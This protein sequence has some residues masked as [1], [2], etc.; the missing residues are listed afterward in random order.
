MALLKECESGTTVLGIL[1]PWYV[2]IDGGSLKRRCLCV[3]LIGLVMFQIPAER[4]WLDLWL[5]DCAANF[6]LIYPN[7][8]D[9]G[10]G[11]PKEAG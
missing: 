7:G 3:I 1:V 5:I 11:C 6:R 9:H 10:F 8:V 4:D 2:V